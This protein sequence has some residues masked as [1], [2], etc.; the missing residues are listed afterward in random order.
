MNVNTT[1]ALSVIVLIP[2]HYETV[3]KT[4]QALRTQTARNRLEIVIVAPLNVMRNI[5]KAEFADF[6]QFRIVKVTQ[7]MTTGDPR[8]EGVRHAN[9]PLVAFAE[10]HAYPDPYWAA[11]LIKAHRKNWAVVAP[12]VVNGTPES[13]FSWMVHFIAY[14][15]WGESMHSGKIQSIPTHSSVYQRKHLLKY[16]ADLGEML[17]FEEHI[18]RGL[19]EEGYQFYL[20]SSAKVYHCQ[21]T[22]LLPSLQVLYHGARNFAATRLRYWSM[23]RRLL[24]IGG[25]PFTASLHFCPHTYNKQNTHTHTYKYTNH[26]HLDHTLLV[27]CL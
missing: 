12:I 19:R 14:G 4:M 22:K 16:G 20:E 26:D 8:A 1:P 24:Y 13:M 7:F 27:R 23:P 6:L 17:Q 3:R 5:D 2:D 25:L 15:S 18:H 21:F 9:A 11:A 10:D